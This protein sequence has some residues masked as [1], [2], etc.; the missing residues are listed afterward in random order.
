M[1]SDM[2]RGMKV[3]QTDG[4]STQPWRTVT[5]FVLLVGATV[6]VFG[7]RLFELPTVALILKSWDNEFFH[8]LL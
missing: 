2:R 3:L 7:L 6:L 1:I 5:S 4:G 8:E